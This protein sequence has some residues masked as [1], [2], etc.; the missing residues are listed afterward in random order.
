M[1]KL[2][3]TSLLVLSTASFAEKLTSRDKIGGS[4]SLGENSQSVNAIFSNEGALEESRLYYIAQ[5][6]VGVATEQDSSKVN[7]SGLQA[8]LAGGLGYL[9]DRDSELAVVAGYEANLKTF[10]SPFY[11]VKPII[12]ATRNITNDGRVK[13]SVKLKYEIGKKENNDQVAA[14]FSVTSGF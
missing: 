14:E 3:V 12:M 5:M 13:A 7:H 8:T 2:I 10:S 1:K 4:I 6:G 11:P 9:I